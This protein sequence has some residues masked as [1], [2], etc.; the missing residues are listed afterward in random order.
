MM[1]SA[2]ASP[3]M[4]PPTAEVTTYTRWGLAPMSRMASRS[5]A[6]ARMAVPMKVRVRNR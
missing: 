3:A 2:P 1:S 5:W 6:T 4:A